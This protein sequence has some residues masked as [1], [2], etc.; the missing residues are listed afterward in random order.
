MVEQ[1]GFI[2]IFLGVGIIINI[3]VSILN[4]NFTAACGWSVAILEWCRRLM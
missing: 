1:L 4:K 2:G 3:V